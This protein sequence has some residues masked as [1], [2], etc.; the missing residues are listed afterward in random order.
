[1]K[2]LISEYGLSEKTA[3]TLVYTSKTLADFFEDVVRLYPKNPQ[4]TANY[5]LNDLLGWLKDEDLKPLYRRLKPSYVAKL[6][7]L[8]DEGVISIRQAKELAEVL[9]K[10]GVDPEELVKREGMVRIA[11]ES[12]LRQLVDQVFKENPKA[13][14]DALVKPKAV[15]YL[16]GMVMAKTRGRADPQLVR[17]LV[18]KKL[19]EVRKHAGQV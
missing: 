10:K 5:I 11:D 8:V 19:E 1:M 17:M 15:N 16:V 13:V 6:M 9:V 4:K 14:K 18:E 2:R 12:Y 3:K 7:K